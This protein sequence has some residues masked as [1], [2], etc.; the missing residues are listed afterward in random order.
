MNCIMYC[1][2]SILIPHIRKIAPERE[3]TMKRTFENSPKA[4]LLEID[5]HTKEISKKCNKHSVSP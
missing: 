3:F 5:S 2:K 4:E 1:M